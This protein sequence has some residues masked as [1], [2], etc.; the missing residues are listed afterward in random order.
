MVVLMAV[1]D[2]INS[3]VGA[4]TTWLSFQAAA[5]VEI[6]ITA[7]CA[8]GANQHIGLSPDGVNR[9][10]GST[11]TVGASG[12][13]IKLGITNTNYLVYYATAAPSFSGIQTK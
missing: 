9:G 11:T 12:F 7:F 10:I 4:A 6:I 8:D 3:G 5:G 2:I 1:G 13:N